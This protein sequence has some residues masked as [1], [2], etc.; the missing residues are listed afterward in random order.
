VLPI[1]YLQTDIDRGYSYLSTAIRTWFASGEAVSMNRTRSTI[2]V[3]VNGPSR[4]SFLRLFVAD[5]LCQSSE[6]N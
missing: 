4:F 6:V 5:V 1:V 3:T 2:Y